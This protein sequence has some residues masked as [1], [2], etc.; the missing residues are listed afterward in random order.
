MYATARD[1]ARF[2]LLYL[3]DGVWN[4]ERILPEGWVDYSRT[5]TPPSL[6]EYGGMWWLN[7]SDGG[8]PETKE[9]P[10]MPEDVYYAS[11]HDGQDVVIFPSQNMIIVRL[12]VSRNGAWDMA[13]F[14]ADVMSAVEASQ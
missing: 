7:A 4:G 12:S 9:W 11:G 5:I 10:D 1:W 14:L 6:G 8:S 3:Q 13:E 2:G